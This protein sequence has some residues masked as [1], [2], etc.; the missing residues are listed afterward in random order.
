MKAIIERLVDL[1]T[2]TRNYVYHPKFK[3]SFS[4]KAVGP[5]LAPEVNY[6]DLELVSDGQAA[7][8]AFVPL[9]NSE[10]SAEEENAIRRALLDYCE[11]YTLA[12]VKVHQALMGSP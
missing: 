12:M 8:A 7:A 6:D 5:A 4:I 1:R 9:T 11:L 2:I 10:I 3:G